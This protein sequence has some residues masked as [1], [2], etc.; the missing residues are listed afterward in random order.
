MEQVLL[1]R[2]KIRD[3]LREYDEIVRPILRFVWCFIV[4]STI[5]SM[6]GYSEI[7]NDKIITILLSVI[8]A[9]FN[10]KFMFFVIG[11]I[12][13]A[14]VYSLSLPVALIFLVMYV[15]MYCIYIKF[16][17][18]VGYVIM[19]SAVLCYFNVGYTVPII[20]A[21]VAG[22]TG[23]VPAAFGVMI[24]D[25]SVLIKDNPAIDEME[26]TDMIPFFMD[27][28]FKNRD[29]ILT[30]IVFAVTIAVVYAVSKIP[31]NYIAYIAVGIGA[32]T[33]IITFIVASTSLESDA[34]T[35]KMFMGVLIALIIAAIIQVFRGILDYPRTEN[36]Q[37]EDDDYFYYV[38]A[39]PKLG[40][41]KEEDADLIDEIR[42]EVKKRKKRP[43]TA[44]TKEKS[45]PRIETPA[46]D[47][48]QT[49][50]APKA[51]DTLQ[52]EDKK[53]AKREEALPVKKGPE[54][55]PSNTKPSGNKS[56][57]RNN[58]GNKGQ[59][60]KAGNGNKKGGGKGSGNRSQGS[61]SK[62]KN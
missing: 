43:E 32:V 20:V 62:K 33:E 52:A 48:P 49:E 23:I 25:F 14:N 26:L 53:E 16:F 56:E 2:N 59:S 24:Y 54:K 9:I 44:E 15:A 40:S 8:F 47:A 34:D 51:K 22:L 11:I 5:N 50:D 4:F 28:F 57:R 42:H 13:V 35:G 1:V 29:M 55:N 37:F 19:L 41:E 45:A 10:E 18:E 38:K 30:I 31:V 39:V 27:N 3:F 6:Y 36:V 17:P 12:L 58:Q 61:G 21:L 46:E 7:F 60:R